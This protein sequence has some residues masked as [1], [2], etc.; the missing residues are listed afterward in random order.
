MYGA[1]TQGNAKENVCPTQTQWNINGV[2]SKRN[3]N[4]Y[5]R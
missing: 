3:G 5:E 1:G 4:F 2:E